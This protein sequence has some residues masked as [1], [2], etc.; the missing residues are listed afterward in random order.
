MPSTPDAARES[1]TRQALDRLVIDAFA[2]LIELI[3][4]HICK[5]E[6]SSSRTL[7][8]K[9]P[10]AKRENKEEESCPNRRPKICGGNRAK[11][12]EIVVVQKQKI[13]AHRAEVAARRFDS[14]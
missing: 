2:N 1:T 5:H 10:Q 7:A 11:Y 12:I 3:D 4:H 9:R 14:H 6:Q 8:S 13:I